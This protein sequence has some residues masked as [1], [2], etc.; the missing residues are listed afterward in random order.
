M[1][2]KVASSSRVPEMLKG[3][4]QVI[5][6]WAALIAAVGSI[7]TGVLSFNGAKRD[8]VQSAKQHILREMNQRVTTLEERVNGQ[9]E[10]NA[11]QDL[12]LQYHSDWICEENEGAP[13]PSFPC[14]HFSW[15]PPP[16]GAL[17]PRRKTHKAYPRN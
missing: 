16:Q 11:I 10:L 4:A 8:D 3:K 15:F 12:R 2:T 9:E 1:S 14:Y 17:T 7:S 5:T 13:H 6:A